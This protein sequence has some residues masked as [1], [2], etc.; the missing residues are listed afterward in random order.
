MRLGQSIYGK[1]SLIP[2]ISQTAIKFLD[3]ERK[4]K[5]SEEELT[6][7]K[8]ESVMSK[9]HHNSSMEKLKGHDTQRNLDQ[10]FEKQAQ[11]DE[12]TSAALKTIMIP[13][14]FS[15]TRLDETNQSPTKISSPSF[16]F[17]NDALPVA[18]P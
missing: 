5:I 4:S 17:L 8:T 14:N 6:K 2:G 1:P 13:N 11:D 15:Y 9:S 16:R 12:K 18:V 3:T 7:T 10:F